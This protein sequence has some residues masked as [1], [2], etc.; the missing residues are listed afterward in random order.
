MARRDSIHEAVKTALVKD[1]WTITDDPLYIEIDG[2]EQS[3]QVDLG[4]EK[5]IGAE[6]DNQQ[7]AVE[8]KTFVAPSVLSGFHTVLGQYL[9]YRDAMIEGKVDRELFLAVSKEVYERMTS[10][11][12]IN[13]RIA[14]YDLK[15]VIVDIV[16][17]EIFQWKQ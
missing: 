6:K 10:I 5:I 13:R 11:K 7:I 12:F 16:E 17:Q 9:D 3:F 8:I 1:G 4:A 14:Q 2:G 15:I